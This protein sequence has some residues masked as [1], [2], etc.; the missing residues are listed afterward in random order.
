VKLGINVY[1]NAPF[2]PAAPP[3]YPVKALPAK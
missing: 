3:A 1:F 2:A